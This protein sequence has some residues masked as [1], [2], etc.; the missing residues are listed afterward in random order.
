MRDTVAAEAFD[1]DVV[2]YDEATH[3]VHV[4]NGTA[5]VIAASFDGVVTI[6]EIARELA[7]GYGV[8]DDEVRAGVLDVAR[9]LAVEWLIEGVDGD[10]V[11]AVATP[12]R[13]SQLLERPPDA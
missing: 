11:R 5:A 8:G 10:D 13:S 4:L 6:D 1:G 12:D 7:T 2:L 9:R 3:G